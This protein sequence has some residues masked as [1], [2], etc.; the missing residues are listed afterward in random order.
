[1]YK[2]LIV[3]DDAF[4]ASSLKFLAEG[5]GYEITAS[6]PEAE[7]L[8]NEMQTNR[9]DLILMD[10]TLKG[11]ID[12]L[13]ATMLLNKQKNAPPVVFLTAHDDE[14]TVRKASQVGSYGYILKPFNKRE[15]QVCIESAIHR[16]KMDVKLRLSEE[17]FRATLKSFADGVAVLD[18]GLKVEFSNFLFTHL[19]K[20]SEEELKTKPLTHFID[21]YE[22]GLPT[23]VLL[24]TLRNGSIFEFNSEHSFSNHKG[25]LYK[26]KSGK[27]CP[28]VMNDNENHGLV[29]TLLTEE[30]D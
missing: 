26:V 6:I 19:V 3:E 22:K 14:L 10:I 16:H 7:L 4:I 27:I 18:Q 30:N 25:E 28:I 23:P 21:F 17:R 1:M 15:L 24:E 8:D 29:L 9:P 13:E 11:N 20:A 5:L 2:V 12:G